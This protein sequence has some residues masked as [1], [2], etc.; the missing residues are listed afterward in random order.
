MKRSTKPSAPAKSA[1]KVIKVRDQLDRQMLLATTAKKATAKKKAKAPPHPISKPPL[2]GPPAEPTKSPSP[3]V[4]ASMQDTLIN[5]L[6]AYIGAKEARAFV[7]EA[8]GL[9][10][11]R[12]SKFAVA[13]LLAARDIHLVISSIWQTSR[14]HHAELQSHFTRD[15][16]KYAAFKANAEPNWDSPTVVM[17]ARLFQ[18]TMCAY[19]QGL[20]GDQQTSAKGRTP[21][22]KTKHSARP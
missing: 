19:V 16:L 12:A 14:R 21:G 2:H 10:H 9:T 8:F 5:D 22:H 15:V 1:Q 17:I 7:T 18:A 6:T 11:P 3:E 4:R 20:N 13:A